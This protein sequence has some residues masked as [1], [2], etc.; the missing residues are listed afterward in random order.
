[1]QNP[2]SKGRHGRENTTA[3]SPD[4]EARGKECEVTLRHSRVPDDE[5]GRQHK[6]GWRWL[7]SMRY[8]RSK[9]S[10]GYDYY[11]S[12]FRAVSAPFALIR[13]FP[14]IDSHRS[15]AKGDGRPTKSQELAPYHS[16]VVDKK[17]LMPGC[18]TC[19]RKVD[20]TIEEVSGMVYGTSTREPMAEADEPWIREWI[21]SVADDMM[22]EHSYMDVS[23]RGIE[24]VSVSLTEVGATCASLLDELI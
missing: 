19:C 24:L 7:L 6:D 4:F 11:D 18:V 15:D 20:C 23:L 17:T 3:F 1:L 10:Y 13:F 5:L 14:A 9:G 2:V 12:D 21:T 8:E 16:K 22:R